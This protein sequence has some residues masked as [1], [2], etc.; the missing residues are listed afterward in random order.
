MKEILPPRWPRTL[1]GHHSELNGFRGDRRNQ[2]RPQ[3]VVIRGRALQVTFWKLYILQTQPQKEKQDDSA[4]SMFQLAL[5][6]AQV[7][8]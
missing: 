5:R 6:P 2:N 7:P 3:D 1:R 4:S 8:L